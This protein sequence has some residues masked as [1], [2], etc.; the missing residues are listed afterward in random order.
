M[1]Q[2][3]VAYR[4]LLFAYPRSFRR[5]RGLEVITTLMDAAEPGRA[6]PTTPE[7]VNLVLSGLKWRFRLPGGPAYRIAAVVVALFIG[8][9]AAAAASEAVWQGSS[10]TPTEAQVEALGRSVTTLVPVQ[11]PYPSAV[12]DG[13]DQADTNEACES[14]AP[15]GADPVVRSVWVAYRVPG[16]EVNAWVEQVRARFTAEGWQIGRTVYSQT[17]QAIAKYP[18]QTIFWAAKGELVVRVSGDPTEK[19]AS[20]G[21]PNVVIGVHKQAPPMVTVAAVVG[22]LVGIT[23]GWMLAGWVLRA[24]Q[25]HTAAG[26]AAM[27]VVGVPVL[28][29]AVLFEVAALVLA[30]YYARALGW[31]QQDSRFPF[32]VLS[33]SPLAL[34]ACG[35]GLFL[36]A[37]FAA[38]APRAPAS[39]QAANDQAPA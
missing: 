19:Y 28:V 25:R 37:A 21:N 30:F 39:C 33:F 32:L 29:L 12:Y 17:D 36:S 3:E 4:R 10:T 22:L 8:L 1:T 11:G 31:S 7:A 15:A 38:V 26:R 35:I 2:L 5:E 6:K 34:A 24:F 27:L 16:A 20:S 14:L 13:C 18:E 9:A 23:A